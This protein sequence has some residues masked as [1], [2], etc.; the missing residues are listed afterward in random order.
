MMRYAV[1]ITAAAAL[2][3]TACSGRLDNPSD[4][5]RIGLRAGIDEVEVTTRATAAPYEGST[6]SSSNILDAS[7][8]VSTS[9][10]SFENS[11]TPGN[12]A[13]LPLHTEIRFNST[14]LVYPVSDVL[15]YPDPGTVYCVGLYPFSASAWTWVTTEGVT[16]AS[17]AI[18]GEDDIMFAPKVSGTKA[19]PISDPLAF[20]HQ[21]TWI[22][23]NVVAESNNAIGMWGNLTDITVTSP[24]DT[25]TVNLSNGSSSCHGS[26]A[27]INAFSGSEA[28]Q[29]TTNTLGSVFCAPAASYSISVTAGSITKNLTVE[30]KG[31]DGITPVSA[32]E[33][34][35]K[36]FVIT[37][38]FNNINIIDASCA[39]VPWDDDN[40]T[41]RGTPNQV[42]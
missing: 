38:R 19:E 28:L 23:I 2:L 29:I 30:L 32:S 33:A 13:S 5:T 1:V 25:Y 37:L 18:N 34:K 39:L 26:P 20:T 7:V 14:G 31:T 15:L 36:L 10:S 42:S 24:F 6:P 40:E 3:L 4:G 41:L 17:H 9:S 27:D 35:G 22:K 8:W 11:G 21:L 16:S 12:L